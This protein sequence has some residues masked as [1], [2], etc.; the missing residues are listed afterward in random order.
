LVE[1]AELHRDEIAKYISFEF[2]QRSLGQLM[3]DE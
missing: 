3:F 1:L 2:G